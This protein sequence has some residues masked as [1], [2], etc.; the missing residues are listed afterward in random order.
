M[1]STTFRE[2]SDSLD[3][4]V[5]EIN[6]VKLEYAIHSFSDLEIASISGRL[7]DLR[8]RIETLKARIDHILLDR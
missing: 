2:I 6:K 3:I 7:S 4:A 1:T 8:S 5:R